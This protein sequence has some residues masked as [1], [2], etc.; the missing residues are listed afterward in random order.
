MVRAVLVLPDY[1]VFLGLAVSNLELRDLNKDVLP[2]TE[3][4]VYYGFASTLF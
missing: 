1:P 3:E 4:S 2:T